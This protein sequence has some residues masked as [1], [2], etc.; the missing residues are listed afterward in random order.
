MIKYAI[1]D[2]DGT[3]I[4]TMDSLMKTGNLTLNQFGFP[5]IG[6]EKYKKFVGYGAK[7][8][9]KSLLID[10]GDHEAALLER[11]YPI[12]MELFAEYCTYQIKPYENIEKLLQKMQEYGIKLAVL[13]NKP[14]QMAEEV[15]A[16]CFPQDTFVTIQGQSDAFPVKPDPAAALYVAKKM[17][18]EDLREVIFM[19]DS[20][21]DMQTA[22]NAGMVAV[23]A[24]WGFRP[25]QEL[26]DNGCEILLQ[27]PLDLLPYLKRDFR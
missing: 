5:A 25:A 17:G 10:S 15:M 19:G 9:V 20:D 18:A 2:L 7:N 13:T 1:F 3:L 26:M 8:L 14:H 21:A 27:D 23:G 11:A 16:N 4:Q 12:Y 24:A 6:L 22:R